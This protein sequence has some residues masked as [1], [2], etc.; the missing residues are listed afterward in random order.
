MY[1]LPEST[2]KGGTRHY[3]E[4]NWFNASLKP[5]RYFVLTLHIIYHLLSSFLSLSSSLSLSLSFLSLSLGSL[6]QS[7]PLSTNSTSLL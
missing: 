5:H 7:R 3:V 4:P 1:I 6:T 2:I